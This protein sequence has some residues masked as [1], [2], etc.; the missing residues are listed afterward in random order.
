MR[1]G[2]QTIFEFV[3]VHYHLDPMLG[4]NSK[5]IVGGKATRKVPAEVSILGDRYGVFIWPPLI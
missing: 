5:D 1:V 2:F 4:L 3:E